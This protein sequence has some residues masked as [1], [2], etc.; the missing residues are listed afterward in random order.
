MTGSTKTLPVLKVI[1]CTTFSDRQDV[2]R[3]CIAFAA[4]YLL[5]ILALVSVSYQYCHTPLLVSVVAVTTLCR[6][7][8]ACV[9]SLSA[10][11]RRLKCSN[12]EGHQ[13][14]TRRRVYDDVPFVV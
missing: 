11:T 7:R 8:P 6:V 14:P 12:A 1:S 3:M 2:V 5:A 9:V 13:E 10:K 4:A